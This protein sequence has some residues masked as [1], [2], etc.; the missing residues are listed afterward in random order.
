MTTGEFVWIM[1]TEAVSEPEFL[2]RLVAPLREDARVALAFCECRAI[3][4][5]GDR[6]HKQISPLSMPA[7]PISFLDETFEAVDFVA[8]FPPEASPLKSVGAILWR[9]DA[10]ARALSTSD[11]EPGLDSSAI[12][13]AI[14]SIPQSRIHFAADTLILRRTR[15]SFE[16]PPLASS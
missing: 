8:R 11:N 2:D 1:E 4:E 10:L 6:L 16:S 9:R 12:Y 13:Q 5:D 14:T 7:A 3:G 15:E